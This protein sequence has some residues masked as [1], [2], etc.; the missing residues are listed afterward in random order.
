MT[1]PDTRPTALITGA[2][3]G[4]GAATARELGQRGF[5]VIVNYHTNAAAAKDVVTAVEA[6][7]G[8]A[9][10]VRADVTVP[11]DVSELVAAA[12]RDTGRIDVLVCNANTAPGAVT[13]DAT[14]GILTPP[15]L[16][17]LAA[18]SVLGRVTGPDD[19]ARVIAALVEGGFDVATGSLIR[20]D[21]GMSILETTPR[22]ALAAQE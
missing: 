14:A 18:T 12:L 15:M 8:S 16:E 21:G 11:D 17:H 19:V 13:T 9:R 4:I 7:G 10:S 6:G 20:L 22:Q 2:S 1:V 5:H 3:R